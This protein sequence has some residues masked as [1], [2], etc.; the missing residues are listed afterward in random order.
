MPPPLEASDS[1]GEAVFFITGTRSIPEIWLCRFRR[2]TDW[3]QK[4]GALAA[5]VCPGKDRHDVSWCGPFAARRAAT[6]AT[7]HLLGRTHV[8]QQRNFPSLRAPR[9]SICRDLPT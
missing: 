6:R 8:E 3:L 5:P 4:L 2:R 1:D 7:R 9:P